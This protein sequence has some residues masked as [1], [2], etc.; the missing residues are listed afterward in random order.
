MAVLGPGRVLS[1]LY[2]RGAGTVRF[3]V[4]LSLKHL[5]FPAAVPLQPE[6]VPQNSRLA[7]L[8]EPDR[9]QSRV[10]AL[11]AGGQVRV[12]LHV[13]SQACQQ[14]DP[15][16]ASRVAFLRCGFLGGVEGNTGKCGHLETTLSG[17]S[18]D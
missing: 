16:A 12:Q 3:P 15:N 6:R 11:W 10:L 18:W 4:V 7:S 14:G 17:F 13:P 8:L 2:Q 1:S 9:P 5:A